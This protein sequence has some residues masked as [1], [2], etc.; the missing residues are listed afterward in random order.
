[1][2][3]PL[4]KLTGHFI[5]GLI[6]S[7]LLRKAMKYLILIKINEFSWFW[8]VC[9]ILKYQLQYVPIIHLMGAL[10]IIFVQNVYIAY[11]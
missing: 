6:N 10:K 11:L 7:S 1:M 3:V 2:S 4:I 9:L 8:N 5:F